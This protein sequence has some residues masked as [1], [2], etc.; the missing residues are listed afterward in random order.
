MLTGLLYLT[1][2]FSHQGINEYIF[3]SPTENQINCRVIIAH[4]RTKQVMWLHV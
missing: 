2:N 1:G 3:I 4:T